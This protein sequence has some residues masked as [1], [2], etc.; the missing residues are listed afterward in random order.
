M[1]PA[2]DDTVAAVARPL[3][4]QAGLDLVDVEVKGGGSRTRVRVVV[5]RKGGVD[6]GTC[7]QLSRKL[8]Q[9]FDADDPFPGRYTLEVTSPGT[10]RPLTDQAAFDRVEGRDVR[11]LHVPGGQPDD[12]A[13]TRPPTEVVGTVVAAR[14]DHVVVTDGDGQEVVVAY[15]DITKATQ[16]LPW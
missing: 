14:P 4:E 8:S 16:V 10:D 15:A 5:D 13:D 9:A 12:T 11:I 3:V 6:V 2:I 1:S 7:Q